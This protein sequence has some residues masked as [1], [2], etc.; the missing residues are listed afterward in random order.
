MIRLSCT[1]L[2]RLH[3][4]PNPHFSCIANY[5]PA[6]EASREAENLTERK[7]QHTP[8]YGLKEFVH[9]SVIKFD[10][11]YLRTGKTKWAEIFLEHLW[12]TAMSP[13]FLFVPKVAVRAGAKGQN[14]NILT[15]HDLSSNQNQKSFGKKFVTLAARA[16]F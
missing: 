7:N 3:F 11:N 9:L 13:N 2:I 15:K 14:S 5:P 16:V 6:R 8:V 1:C 10:T 12:R 4:W